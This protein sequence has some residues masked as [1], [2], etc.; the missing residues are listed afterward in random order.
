MDT[1][2]YFDIFV[3][4]LVVASTIG[5]IV[6]AIADANLSGALGT[7][8]NLWPLG[9]GVSILVLSFKSSKKK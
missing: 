3:L 1:D 6:T 5:S 8:A 7:I 9:L 4:I 2:K